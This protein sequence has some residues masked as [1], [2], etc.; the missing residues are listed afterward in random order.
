[1]TS[2][3]RTPV[4]RNVERALWAESLGH[5]MNPTCRRRLLKENKS[6]AHVAHIIPHATGGNMSFDN[7]LH[8]CPSCHVDIDQNEEPDRS[9]TLKSWKRQR[10]QVL[11]RE[12]TTKFDSFEELKDVV[13]PLLMENFQ[14]YIDYGPDDV[15]ITDSARYAQWMK[16][17]PILLINNSILLDILSANETLLAT[18]NRK[19]VDDL[20]AHL[21]EFRNTRPSGSA[22]RLDFFPQ[23]LNSIFG[24]WPAF[25]SRPTE[26]IG[27]LENFI[28]S[29]IAES[30]YRDIDLAGDGMVYYTA[31]NGHVA[32]LSIYDTPRAFQEYWNRRSY[33]ATMRIRLSD[34]IWLLKW[35]DRAGIAWSIPDPTNLTKVTVGSQTIIFIHEYVGGI[36]ALTE[37]SLPPGAIVV[38][39]NEWGSGGYTGDAQ[40][41]A[42]G[43]GNRT[44]TRSEFFAEARNL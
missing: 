31:E 36:A 22:E 8:L 21:L 6:I 3:G 38:N 25:S 29:L 4:T 7:L 26:N 19:L 34:L 28:K 33:P 37:I 35:M 13:R 40:N 41:Y 43:Q 9:E 44:M 39:T 23:D 2:P 17:E 24:I 10:Q 20:R 27:A 16:T 32:T 15:L 11:R 30:R 5:C 18:P 14:I 1:M 42:Q 12:L